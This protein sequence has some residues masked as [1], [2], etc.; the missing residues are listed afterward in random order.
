MKNKMNPDL[1]APLLTGE[2]LES[3]KPTTTRTQTPLPLVAGHHGRRRREGE[4]PVR[5]AMGGALKESRRHRG[6][7]RERPRNH[8]FFIFKAAVKISLENIFCFGDPI[9][10][11]NYASITISHLISCVLKRHNEFL[12]KHPNI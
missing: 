8:V 1:A 6:T 2:E 4:R 5:G 11:N 10:H 9:K 7:Q 12:H 3:K